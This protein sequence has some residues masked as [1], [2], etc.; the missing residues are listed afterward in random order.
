MQD[1][2]ELERACQ[3]QQILP[4]LDDELYVNALGGQ[5][6]EGAIVGLAIHAPE[7]RPADVGQ[8][9]AE[10]VAQEM[11]DAEDRVGVGPGVGHD[12]GRLQLGLLLQHH[13]KQREAV[14]QGAGHGDAVEPGELVRDQVVERGPTLLTEVARVRPRMDRADGHHEAQPVSRGDVTAAPG[15]GERDAVLC[16]DQDGVRPGERLGPDV[17]LPHPAQP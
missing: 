6:V 2:A 11:K 5:L 17:V 7:P 13:G 16:R 4:V 8:T 14:A 15:P 10:L 9:R 1:S 12:L 3:A